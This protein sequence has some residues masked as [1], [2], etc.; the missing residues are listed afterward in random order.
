MNFKVYQLRRTLGSLTLGAALLLGMS[1]MASAQ[2]HHQRHE[3][4]DLREHQ[5]SER[6][7]YGD[8]RALREH[9]RRER[10]RLEH[11]QR[12]ERRGYYNDGYYNNDRY[13]NGR[14]NDGYYNNGRY[15]NGRYNGGDYGNRD[16]WRYNRRH[17]RYFRW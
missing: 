10:H 16:S 4:R 15:N 3:R 8:S 17:D 11:H 14:F 7:Y 5:R 1:V 12:A 6:Y 2:G 9:Q 13:N